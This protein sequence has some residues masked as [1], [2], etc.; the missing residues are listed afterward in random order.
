MQFSW[1]EAMMDLI[2]NRECA[3]LRRG[4]AALLGN[5]NA[6]RPAVQGGPFYPVR[7]GGAQPAS[8][9]TTRKV[10]RLARPVSR[11]NVPALQV[12]RPAATR[13]RAHCT[14]IKGRTGA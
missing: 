3:N 1:R 9:D 7:R 4:E 11:F 6:K 13:C 5:G 2:S 14:F 10:L 8:R 12:A